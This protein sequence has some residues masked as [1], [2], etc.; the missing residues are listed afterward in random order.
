MARPKIRDKTATR[1]KWHS[2]QIGVGVHPVRAQSGNLSEQVNT[3]AA[4]HAD[5]HRLAFDG[6]LAFL[7][8][9]YE[10]RRHPPHALLGTHHRFQPRSLAPQFGLHRLFRAIGHLFKIGIESGALG[11]VELGF[12]QAAFVVDADGRAVLDRALDVVHV[13]VLA[14]H[15]GMLQSVDSTGV[16]VKPMKDA[17]GRASRRCLAKPQT[18][19]TSS[20]VI[21]TRALKPY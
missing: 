15:S 4:A 5:D 21:T 9:I 6:L 19:R 2:T 16:P 10:V 12:R 8:V 13:N 11:F 20:S 14:E 7:K 18:M 17:P 1:R 3:D